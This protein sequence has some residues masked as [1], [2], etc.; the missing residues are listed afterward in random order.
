MAV[1]GDVCDKPV[2]G[3]G[4][5]VSS[6]KQEKREKRAREPVLLLSFQQREA[7]PHPSEEGRGLQP[8]FQV[9]ERERRGRRKRWWWWRQEDLI[10]SA[11]FVSHHSYPAHFLDVWVIFVCQFY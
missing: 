4:V 9:E 10:A 5:V 11:Q 6:A 1:A 8:Q 3:R 2:G 7:G